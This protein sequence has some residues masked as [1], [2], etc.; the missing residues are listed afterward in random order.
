MGRG[1]ALEAAKRYPDLPKI[2]GEKIKQNGNI[3][4]PL[5]WDSRW[6]IYAFPVKHNWWEIADLELIEQSC[7]QLSELTRRR[8]YLLPRPGCGNGKLD[9]ETQVKPICAKYLRSNI[10]IVSPR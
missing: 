6:I 1:C 8:T 5:K 10:I 7:K 2:L 4:Q 3:V 9:W